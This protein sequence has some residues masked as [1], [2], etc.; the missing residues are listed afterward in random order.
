MSN[1]LLSILMAFFGASVLNIGQASQKIGLGLAN[2]RKRFAG[3]TVWVIGTLATS[4]AVFIT[5]YA[6][7]LGSASIV[8]AMAGSGLASLTIF[9]ALVMKEKIGRREILGVV[10][11]LGGAALIGGFTSGEVSTTMLMKRLYVMLVVLTVAGVS[12]WVFLS[13]RS[14]AGIVIGAFAGILGGF[15]PLFQRVS[16]SSLAKANTFQLP[17][18]FR[19]AHPPESLIG[20]LQELFLNPYALIWIILSVASMIVLQFSYKKDKAIR[21]IPSFSACY[22]VLPVIGGVICFKE[23]ITLFQW[24]GILLILAGVLFITLK[25]EKQDR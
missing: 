6:V 16:L 14:V 2:S 11:I 8:G 12:G 7:S 18:L 23:E 22:I 19:R 17:F 15:V 4:V 13:Q 25:K 1:P 9:S 24:P 20:K 10:T 3:Y 21:I 5:L